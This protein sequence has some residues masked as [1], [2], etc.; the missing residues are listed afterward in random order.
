M[1]DVDQPFFCSQD[2]F[3][4]M[5]DMALADG[6]RRADRVYL[7]ARVFGLGRSMMGLK[8][9]VDPWRECSEGRLIFTANVYTVTPG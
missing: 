9:Y 6:F 3:D 1:G 8:L 7:I 2:Q 4:K 5:E